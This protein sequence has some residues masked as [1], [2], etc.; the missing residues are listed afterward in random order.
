MSEQQ[1][2]RTTTSLRHLLPKRLSYL[3]EE[4]PLLWFE[5]TEDYDALLAELIAEYDPKGTMEF[6]LV[7]DLSDAQWE[8]MRLRQLRQAAVEAEVPSAAWRLM[9]EE[10]IAE[11]GHYF[12]KAATVLRVMARKAVQGDAEMAQAFEEHSAHAGVTY[13]MMHYEAIKGG[14]KSIVA[15]EDALARSERR[16]DQLVRMIEERRRRLE[17][18]TRSLVDRPGSTTAIEVAPHASGGKAA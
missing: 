11:T 7:K 12:E 18:M 13:S 3:L 17:P 14:M 15:L 16:R 9:K 8:T 1:H 5:N 2:P 6:I 4:R 10:F